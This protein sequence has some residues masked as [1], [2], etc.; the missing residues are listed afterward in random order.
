MGQRHQLFIISNVNGRYRTL[1]A[2]HHQWL[3]G[4]GPT[5]ACWRMLQILQNPTN[6][7]L[8]SH[9]LREAATHPDEWW[10]TLKRDSHWQDDPLQF[11]FITTCLVLGAGL[12]PRPQ[13]VYRH[14][15]QVLSIT[16]DFEEVDNNDGLTM[17]DISNLDSIRYCFLQ[18][19]SRGMRPLTG[20]QYYLGYY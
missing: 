8:I 20:M 18:L 15:V 6:K 16:T 10:K 4:A 12:D 14:D 5:K 3:Y 2:V 11:P 13:F 9:E 1:A 19:G 7:K 17:I